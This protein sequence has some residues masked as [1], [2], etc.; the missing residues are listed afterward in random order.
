MSFPRNLLRT[1]VTVNFDSLS[2]YT[3]MAQVNVAFGM[4]EEILGDERFIFEHVVQKGIAER[5]YREIVKLG[6]AL[7]LST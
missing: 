2:V 1:S 3:Y 5:E 7:M 4:D 6:N